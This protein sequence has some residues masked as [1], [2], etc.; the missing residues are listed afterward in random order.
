MAKYC[1]RECHVSHAA[2]PDKCRPSSQVA[3]YCSR[4]CQTIHWKAHKGSCTP[5]GPDAPRPSIAACVRKI[6]KNPV[7]PTESAA[8]LCA[9]VRKLIAPHMA[10]L[11]YTVTSAEAAPCQLLLWVD[12]MTAPAQ[13]EVRFQLFLLCAVSTC[14]S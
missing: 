12:M 13:V 8:H 2:A 7:S 4:E 10:A 3:K 5:L 6:A 1:S 9:L 14:M 11:G